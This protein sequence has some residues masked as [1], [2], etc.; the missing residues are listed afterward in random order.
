MSKDTVWRCVLKV[1]KVLCSNIHNYIKWPEPLQ[2]DQSQQKFA[3]IV[4]LPGVIGAIDGCH[5]Q[6]SAPVR[7]SHCY[8]NRKGY[9]S[10]IL[11]GIC[12]TSLKFI[13]VFAGICGSV[14]DS[15]VW[16]MSDIKHL[17]VN[18]DNRYFQDYYYIIGDAAYPLSNRLLT[19]YRD[20]GHLQPW[21]INY[22]TKHAKTRV[23]IERAFGMLL[24]R[25]RK[26][27]Y[28]YAYNTEFVPF[29]ILACCILHNICINNEEE[30]MV[31]DPAHINMHQIDF[32]ADLEGNIKRDSLLHVYYN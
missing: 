14:H 31:I 3:S 32:G 12:D 18:N 19:P 6:I 26:L 30:E 2:M 5:I 13:D 27:K 11:Q 24:G 15:R 29:I 16:Y 9:Y 20:N 10:I 1:S 21:Q 7:D 17:I 8:I 4:D 28:V 23:I 25:F 22:N